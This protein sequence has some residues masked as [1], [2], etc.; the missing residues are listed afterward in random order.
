VR[1]AAKHDAIV[2]ALGTLTAVIPELQVYGWRN[3]DP[4]PPSI[5]LYPAPVFQAGA[6]FGE[7]EK[8]VVFTVRARVAQNDSEAGQ[9]V[10]LRLLDPDDPASVEAALANIDVMVGN[11]QTVSGFQDD[12]DGMLSCE[13]Q[14]GAFI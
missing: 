4:T 9:R 11:E 5:D 2:A 1:L 10:L 6:G 8:A 14:V 12:S 3:P 13:W 7:A